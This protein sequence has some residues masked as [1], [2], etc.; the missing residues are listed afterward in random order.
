MTD[1]RSRRDFLRLVATSATVGRARPPTLLADDKSDDKCKKVRRTTA[2]ASP[3]SARAGRAWATP[4]RPSTCPGS[5][6]WPPATSTT[7]RLARAKEIWGDQDSS[8]PATTARS[9][10]ARTWTRSSSPPPTTGTCPSRSRPWRRARTSTARSPWCGWPARAGSSW[11]PQKRTGRI[12]RW[13]ASAPSSIVYAKARDLVASGAIG[14]LNLVEAWWNRNTAIGAWQYT[15]PPDAS[16][17][18]RRLGPL[19]GQRAQAAVRAHP[20][21]PLAQLPGLRHRRGG[22]PLRAPLLRP[23]L[24]HG[25]HRAHAG[26]RHGRPALLEGRPRRARRDA[27]AL[28]LPEDRQ[29]RRVHPD[30]E[31]ELRRRLGRGRGLPLRGLRGRHE[32]GR[33]RHHPHPAQPGEGARL[34]HL[35]FPQKMQD[36]FLKDYR[37]G[38]RSGSTR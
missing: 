30:P 25:G 12:C 24:H 21:L 14:E 35:T 16:P 26:L 23:P 27:R 37:S 5:S 13:A 17:G 15:I 1:S 34:H 28:R 4:G 33:G 20:P 8:P 18:D 19:P 7:G 38:I 36:E 32:P 31:G 10:T 9:S 29:P 3:S 6:S 2:S 22:R 11:R